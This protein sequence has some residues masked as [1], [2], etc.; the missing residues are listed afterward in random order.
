MK[1]KFMGMA[2]ATVMGISTLTGCAT[3]TVE[4]AGEAEAPAEAPAEEA[5]ATEE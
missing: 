3:T 2:M 5:V 4:E 1:K